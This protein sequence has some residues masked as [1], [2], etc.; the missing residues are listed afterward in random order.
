MNER[1]ST[2]L[3][4]TRKLD[5]VERKTQLADKTCG[6]GN[7]KPGLSVAKMLE[8]QPECLFRAPALWRLQENPAPIPIELIL[9]ADKS[10]G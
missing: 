1:N 10:T 6:E 9:G 5:S 3:I 8:P 7:W 2:E 4:E